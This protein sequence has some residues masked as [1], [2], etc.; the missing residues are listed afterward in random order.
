MGG[1]RMRTV[2]LL[3][4]RRL[5]PMLLIAFVA[6]ATA[7]AAEYWYVHTEIDNPSIIEPTSSNNACGINAEVTFTCSECRDFDKKVVDGTPTT[8]QDT[9]TY[10]WSCYTEAGAPIDG[11]FPYGNKARSVTWRAPAT[12]GNYIVRVTVD[13]EDHRAPFCDGSDNDSPK[14]A[15][16]TMEVVTLR[17]TSPA[18]GA[19]VIAATSGVRQTLAYTL[20]IRCH[21]EPA[22]LAS[23]VTVTVHW[24]K[25]GA[26]NSGAAVPLGNGDFQYGLGIAQ[27]FTKADQGGTSY[28]YRLRATTTYKGVDLETPE[29]PY[30]CIRKGD[31]IWRT[32]AD[33]LHY[34]YHW[35]GKGPDACHYDTSHGIPV[36]GQT[37]H[38]PY[39]Q[40]HPEG[41]GPHPCCYDCSG[42]S[43]KMYA[44]HGISI[45]DGTA[46][47]HN[48][49]PDVV[50]AETGDLL[51]Y[52]DKNGIH[53]VSINGSENRRDAPCTGEWTQERATGSPDYLDG[54][55]GWG[56]CMDS[57]CSH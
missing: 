1:H 39:V 47:Q 27:R 9:V 24:S 3:R 43:R 30:V 37:N 32:A 12:P 40:G 18:D 52:A 2:A 8:P 10:T 48:A 15:Q 23:P 16:L 19:K 29:K 53:H 14:Q 34:P 33:W 51:F 38:E 17:M 7:W 55:S 13:D 11:T 49:L 22:D 46:N 44:I 5:L 26:E 6:P 42:F 57:T 28:R 56:W 54:P 35:N 50:S 25:A 41:D 31:Q 21:F 45:P 36:D 20:F 4:L